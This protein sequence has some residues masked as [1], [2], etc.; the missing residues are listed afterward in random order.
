MSLQKTSYYFT[1]IDPDYSIK[2]SRDPLGFQVIWQHQAKKLIPFLSTVSGS[3]RDFQVLSLA[4]HLY[5]DLNAGFMPFFIRFE[6]LIAY[7][8]FTKGEKDFNGTRKVAAIINSDPRTL[9]LSPAKRDQILTNQRAYGIWGKY[10]R[11]YT[12]MGI[13]KKPDFK[14]IYSSKIDNLTNYSSFIQLINKLKEKE[15]LRI[16]RHDIE[17]LFELFEFTELEIEFYEQN[18]LLVHDPY[19]FQ[20]QL[21]HFLQKNDFT[22][23]SYQLLHTIKS[24]FS[25]DPTLTAVIDEIET[26]EKILCPLNRIFKYLQTKPIWTEAMIEADSY[27]NQC[28]LKNDF[29]FQLTSEHNKTKNQLSLL[30]Q[31]TNWEIA[32]ELVDRNNKVTKEREGAGWMSWRGNLIEV[33]HAEG[34]NFIPTF[35]PTLD[36]DNDYFFNTYISLFHQIQRSK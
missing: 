36:F 5:G 11:P 27:I 2:G 17:I 6:Q 10:N 3:L 25:Y 7:A 18:L 16:P 33:H 28:K 21:F 14:M 13:L 20:N 12:E 22:G 35:D 23:F 29:A 1:D 15:S 31:K 9:T 34:R 30:F 8:R 4:H 26:T 24:Y 32:I 19:R